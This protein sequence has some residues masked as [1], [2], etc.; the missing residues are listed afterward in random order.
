MAPALGGLALVCAWAGWHWM[1]TDYVPRAEAGVLLKQAR[2]AM[3]NAAPRRATLLLEQAAAADNRFVEARAL[4][5]AGYAGLDQPE[6]ARDAALDAASASDRRWALG[7]GEQ[8]A[9]RAARAAVVRNYQEAATQYRLWAE[10][11][12]GPRRTFALVSAGQALDLAG[13]RDAALR[14]MEDAAQR[15]PVSAGPRIRLGLLLNR[16]GKPD[17]ARAEFETAKAALE[18][19]GNLEGLSD[20]LL[21]R[22]GARLGGNEQDR[23]DVERVLT[24]SAKT[25][26]RYHAVTAKF[27]MA[28]VAV[29]KRDYDGAVRI[30][31]ET[32][33]EARREGMPVVAAQA[34][35][36]L[37]YSFLYLK[38]PEMAVPILREAVEMAERARA[39][40]ILASSQLRL[41]EA[42]GH[43]RQFDASIAVM[44]PAVRWMRRS[45]NQGDFPLVLIKWGTILA[46]TPRYQHRE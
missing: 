16:A 36:E 25:G 17:R 35:S 28:G 14:T 30:A 4:L 41:G 21:A 18:R 44:E 11:E 1:R 26:N 40:G 6:K 20:L 2:E 42:L 7:R 10:M 34:L 45:G 38:R 37:G 5:A 24:L 43:L 9:L 12:T 33:E 29:L 39:T 15:D 32:A 23:Q 13:A 27:R 8:L 31:R 19:S 22:S 46:V 3:A